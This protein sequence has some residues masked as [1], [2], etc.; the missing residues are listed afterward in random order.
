M[1]EFDRVSKRFASRP[2]I[3]DLSMRIMR[4]TL[5][6]GFSESGAG[7]TLRYLSNSFHRVSSGIFSSGLRKL[8]TGTVRKAALS[9]VR[10]SR[11]YRRNSSGV[12]PTG[13]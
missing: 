1:A 9:V 5:K 7:S 11:T 13:G 3:E 4:G 12:A 10:F 8:C 6:P 2:L